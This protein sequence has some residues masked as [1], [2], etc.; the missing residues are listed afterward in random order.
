MSD[1]RSPSDIFN[2]RQCPVC[3]FGLVVHVDGARVF[4]RCLNREC[5]FEGDLI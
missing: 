5:G 3:G 4:L 1:V 2:T